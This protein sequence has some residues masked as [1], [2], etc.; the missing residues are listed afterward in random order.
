[1]FTQV[2]LRDEVTER[3][4]ANPGLA[5]GVRAAAIR[6]AEKHPENPDAILYRMWFEHYPV[7][8]EKSAAERQLRLSD[9]YLRFQPS[10]LRARLNRGIAL[11]HC[12]R[13]GEAADAFREFRCEIGQEEGYRLGF[14]CLALARLEKFDAARTALVEMDKLSAEHRDWSQTAL[15]ELMTEARK[16]VPPLPIPRAND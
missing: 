14:L 7:S 2:P 10:A 4:K 5:L 1:L 13:H 6:L 12:G 11:Y 9:A 15:G 8:S 3:L 16:A